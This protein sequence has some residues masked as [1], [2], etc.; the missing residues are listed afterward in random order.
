ME[1]EERVKGLNLGC[2]TPVS[3]NVIPAEKALNVGHR[4]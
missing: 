2:D 3:T 1:G 4:V